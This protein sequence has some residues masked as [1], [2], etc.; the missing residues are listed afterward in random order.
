VGP[1]FDRLAARWEAIPDGGTLTIR[2]PSL[3][4]D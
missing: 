3:E 2:W 1:A 4:I